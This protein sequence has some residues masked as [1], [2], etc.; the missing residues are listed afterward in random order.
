MHLD[1]AVREAPCAV[2]HPDGSL[3][4]A[5]SKTHV[6]PPPP[7]TPKSLRQLVRADSRRL[8]PSDEQKAILVIL[9]FGVFLECFCTTFQAIHSARLHA[10]VSRAYPYRTVLHPAD[11][12]V[13]AC[14]WAGE[15]A[16]AAVFYALGLRALILAQ[17]RAYETFAQVALFGVFLQPFLLALA[18]EK[19]AVLLF[20]RLL[21]HGVANACIA[22]PGVP[23]TRRLMCSR[24]QRT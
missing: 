23:L 14:L 15:V 11:P 21:A 19:S 1:G 20:H 8:R 3:A 22:Q 9:V 5:V 4:I 6:E 24:R 17:R 2:R 10:A 7:E 12:L 16:F 18:G 13:L